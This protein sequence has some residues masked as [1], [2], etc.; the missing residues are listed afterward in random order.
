ML[1]MVEFCLGLRV[2]SLTLIADSFHELNDSSVVV[3]ALIIHMVWFPI[4]ILQYK[5]YNIFICR[6][7]GMGRSQLPS[8]DNKSNQESEASP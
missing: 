5:T 8:Y 4:F 6:R 3:V 2:N 7:R 1:F